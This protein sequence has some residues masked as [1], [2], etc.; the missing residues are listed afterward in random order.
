MGCGGMAIRL[1]LAPILVGA[2]AMRLSQKEEVREEGA[3]AVAQEGCAAEVSMSQ[4]G[5]EAV[6]L[7]ACWRILCR[8]SRVAGGQQIS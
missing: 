1:A 7:R 5:S 4:S 3:G 2:G 8:P 6:E